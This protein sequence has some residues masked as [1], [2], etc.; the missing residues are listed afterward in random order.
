[1]WQSEM[2]TTLIAKAAKPLKVL[3]RPVFCAVAICA[4]A[5]RKYAPLAASCAC[6]MTAFALCMPSLRS[7]YFSEEGAIA[8]V[9][10]GEV[11][12]AADEGQ[13]VS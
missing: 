11:V 4:S 10:E 9:P 3:K 12:E 6:I 7:G 13:Q 1:M 2:R 8:V 5:A